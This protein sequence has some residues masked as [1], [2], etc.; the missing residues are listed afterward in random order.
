[1]YISHQSIF[2]IPREV[3]QCI[4]MGIFYLYYQHQIGFSETLV[5]HTNTGTKLFVYI[6]FICSDTEG[7]Q[8]KPRYPKHAKY[9]YHVPL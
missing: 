5:M 7:I 1:M 8:L 6:Y 9:I 2:G 4:N 3:V